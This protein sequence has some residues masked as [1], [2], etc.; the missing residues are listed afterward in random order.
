M[1]ERLHRRGVRLG[2]LLG[3]N[4]NL[5]WSLLIIFG[6]VVL[7]LA[8]GYLPNIHPDWSTTTIWSTATIAG[9]LFFASVLLHSVTPTTSVDDLVTQHLMRISERPVPV[10]EDGELRGVVGVEHVRTIPRDEWAATPVR[11]IMQ[12]REAVETIRVDAPAERV[13]EDDYR[14]CPLELAARLPEA[15]RT[16]S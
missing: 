7:S 6:L 12:R 10:L 5:D 1:A 16:A 3:I 4:I 11:S 14:E 13:D 2:S 8:T 15:S 9:L